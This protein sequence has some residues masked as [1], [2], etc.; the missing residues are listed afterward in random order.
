MIPQP[1]PL[2]SCD[3]TERHH[4]IKNL[5]VRRNGNDLGLGYDRG[6]PLCRTTTL[7]L[8]RSLMED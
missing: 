7:A 2:A 6:S 1:L 5:L 3:V 4:R 8:R